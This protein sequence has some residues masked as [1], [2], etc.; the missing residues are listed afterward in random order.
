MAGHLDEVL[1]LK[2][3]RSDVHD[4]DLVAIATNTN[5]VTILDQTSGHCEVLEAHEDVVLS[6]S[7]SSDGR[8]LV[9][10]SKVLHLLQ[11]AAIVLFF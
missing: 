5:A 1:D 9:S 3:M 6:L 7:C 8:I 4:C 10:S 2:Y 11:S